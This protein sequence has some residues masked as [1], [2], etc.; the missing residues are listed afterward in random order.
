MERIDPDWQ[1][2]K[3]RK[4]SLSEKEGLRPSYAIKYQPIL[5]AST[6]HR[7]LA[8]AYQAHRASGKKIQEVLE[9]WITRFGLIS[10]T[11]ELF[12]GNEFMKEASQVWWIV[13]VFDVLRNH[14]NVDGTYE[15]MQLNETALLQIIESGSK[16]I[17][18]MHRPILKRND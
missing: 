5:E 2:T 12:D 3:Y 11:M 1:W 6:L 16:T 8:Q 4:V 10:G 7:S 15:S 18:L 13:Q 9:D 17:E 14:E